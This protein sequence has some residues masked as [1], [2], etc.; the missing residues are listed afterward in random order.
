MKKIVIL[1]LLTFTIYSV[2]SQNETIEPIDKFLEKY[3]KETPGGVIGVVKSGKIIYQKEFGSANLD[4]TFPNKVNT[5]FMI[6]SLTKQFTG[7]CIAMLMTECKVNLDDDIRKYL[8]EFPFYGDTI[9]IKN[10]LYHT[11]GIKNYGIA[12][13]MSG[14]INEVYNDYDHLLHLIYSQSSL[15]FKPGTKYSY[16]N[17]NYT[18]LGEIVHRVTGQKVEEYAKHKIFEPLGMENTFYW[19]APNKIIRNKATGY[20]PLGNGEYEISQPLW[21]PYGSG[22]IIS[23]LI[24][25]NKWCSFLIEQYKK[26]TDF[27][28]IFTKTGFTS[29]EKPTNF[30]LGLNV[31]E[32][33]GLIKYEHNGGL[34]GFRS[35]ITIFPEQEL[36]IVVLGNIS[37]LWTYSATCLL[38]DHYL[39]YQ[40]T[41]GNDYVVS[42]TQQI[43]AVPDDIITLDPNKLITYEDYYEFAD[44]FMFE[45]KPTKY[46]LNVWES[47]NNSE[48]KVYPITDSSFIDSA[49]VVRFDFYNIKNNKANRLDVIYN[50]VKST[51][52]LDHVEPVNNSVLMELTG[53]YFD[54]DLNTVYHFYLDKERFLVR[55][56]DNIP[57]RVLVVNKNL[58]SF[59]GYEAIIKRDDN[60]NVTG[61]E[62]T[63]MQESR[64]NIFTKIASDL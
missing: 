8:P 38:A 43:N 40:F 30:A 42:T 56:G 34:D 29:D 22:N 61:F 64:N 26:Q 45:I 60:N 18:L 44:G 2:Y 37:N 52:V 19:T 39:K 31:T 1:I 55:I 11:S 49:G 59:Y 28:K 14:I 15:V 54:K 35:R 13:K 12:M 57:T 16:S 32:Y 53:F 47:W 9:R 63:N 62:L 6:G 24:D 41:N 46:G 36:S 48:Y 58:L 21:V 7:A 33:R 51:A 27:I 20:S 4:Y 10:L 17:S 5:K 3:N 23:T 25:L 50:G